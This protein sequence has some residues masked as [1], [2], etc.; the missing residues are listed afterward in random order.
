MFIINENKKFIYWS[1][2]KLGT[3]TLRVMTDS[4]PLEDLGPCVSARESD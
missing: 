2:G 4:G 1:K 3:T